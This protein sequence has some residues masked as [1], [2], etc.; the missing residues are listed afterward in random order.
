MS[1]L[2]LLED[3]FE[4]CIETADLVQET[5]LGIRGDGAD[6]LSDCAEEE[7]EANKGIWLCVVFPASVTAL[8]SQFKVVQ[9]VVEDILFLGKV[10]NEWETIVEG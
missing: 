9:R 1:V 10:S 6:I 4:L 2:I 8:E 3:A 5:T 7:L